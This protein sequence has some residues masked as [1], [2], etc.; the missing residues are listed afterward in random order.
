MEKKRTIFD[1]MGQVFMIFG[2]TMVVLNIF[3]I[4]FGESAKAYSQMFSL[5]NQGLS[6]QT[7]LQFFLVSICITTLRFLFF[8][9][10][11]LKRMTILLRTVLMVIAVVIVIGVFIVVCGWFQ[12]NM[13]VPWLLFFLSFGVSF[14]I[15]MGVT[16]WKERIENR[17]MAEALERLKEEENQ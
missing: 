8:T 14:G 13:W 4:L 11:L 7:A 12:V 17:K 10:L 1:Y 9:D 3:C 5:G 6:V 16:I 2:I 15:S